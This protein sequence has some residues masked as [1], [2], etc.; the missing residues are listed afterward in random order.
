EAVRAWQNLGYPRRALRLHACAVM[1]A[2]RHGGVVPDDVES[3]L[4]LPGV[5]EYT[6]RAVAAFA[7]GRRHPVV[8]TNVRR[9]LARAVGGQAEPGPPNATRD[10]AAMSALLPHDER[11][12]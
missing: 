4:R 12:A 3:L 5:G 1:I 10:L 6:A 8:D 9:V 11:A 7:Y 2:E